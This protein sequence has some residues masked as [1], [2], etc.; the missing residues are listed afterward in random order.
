MS[1]S[2]VSNKLCVA[3]I[4]I[5][6]LRKARTARESK[7]LATKTSPWQAARETEYK[8]RSQTMSLRQHALDRLGRLRSTGTNSTSITNE[9]LNGYHARQIAKNATGRLSNRRVEAFLGLCRTYTLSSQSLIDEMYAIC[10]RWPKK[11]PDIFGN[12][13]LKH[14]SRAMFDALLCTQDMKATHLFLNGLINK[15]SHGKHECRVLRVL[16]TRSSAE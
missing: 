10:S 1:G 6:V 16:T 13:K 14:V 2:L 15:V 8:D 7:T 5:A 3:Y 9:R 12:T 4:G 11:S